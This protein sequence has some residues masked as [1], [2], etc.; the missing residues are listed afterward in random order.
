MCNVTCDQTFFFGEKG[1]EGP[2][3]RRLE[4]VSLREHLIAWKFFIVLCSQ[5]PSQKGRSNGEKGTQMVQRLRGS[6]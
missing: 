5:Q 1:E 3:D 4:V 6:F 2:H